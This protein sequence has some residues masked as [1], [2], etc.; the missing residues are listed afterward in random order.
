MAPTPP[1]GPL[2]WIYLLLALASLALGIVGLFLPVV[3]TA[4]FVLVAAW[5]AARSSPRLHAWLEA[6]PVFGPPIRDWR[7]GGVVRRRAKWLATGLMDASAASML[8]FVG[9]EAPAIVAIAAM[10]AV[11]AW[12]W[13]RPERP[14][15]P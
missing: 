4:P 13:R 6:H 9:P 5:A 3:P 1:R 7:Q 14:P 8:V 2:R 12:L 10:A 11:L 15:H